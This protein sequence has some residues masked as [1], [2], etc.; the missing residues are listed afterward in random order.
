LRSV[1]KAYIASIIRMAYCEETLEIQKLSSL[2]DHGC[3]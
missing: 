3:F 1:L 2:Y